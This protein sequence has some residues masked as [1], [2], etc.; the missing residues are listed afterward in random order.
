MEPLLAIGYN[1]KEKTIAALRGLEVSEKHTRFIREIVETIT[2]TLL[3]LFIIRFAVQSFRTSGQSMEPDFHNNEYVLVNKMAYLFQQPQRGDVVIFHYPF[4]IHKDFIKRLVGLP[5]DTIHVTSSNVIIN[6]QTIREPYIRVPFNFEGNT[7]KLGPD[8]FFVMG[9]NRDNSLDSRIWGPLAR[10][11]IIGKVV[12]AYWP[13]NYLGLI[14]TYP[15]V[16]AEVPPGKG[17]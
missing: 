8:Q 13:M 1:T 9:D 3:I 16:Y 11:Y 5:G 4:D 10:S 7:W 17:K 2:Y 12:V 15:S 6:G 14:N